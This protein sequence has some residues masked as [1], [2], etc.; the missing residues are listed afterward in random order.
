MRNVIIQHKHFFLFIVSLSL[1]RLVYINFIPLTPQEAY[2]WY[3][4]LKPALSYFDHPPMAAYSIWLGTW[5]FGKSV[6]GVK[7]M[8]VV[9]STLTNILIYVTVLRTQEEQE[10]SQRKRIA[11]FIIILFNLTIFAHLYS[12]VIVPDSPLLFFWILIIFLTREFLKSGQK[13]YLFLTAA[14]LGVGIVSKYTALAVLPAIF[15][16][17][18]LNPD[19]RRI[20]LKPYPYLALALA[21]IAFG[22]VIYWNFSHDWVSFKFQFGQRTTS[23]IKPLQLK[24]FYQ[25]IASQLFVLTPYI[26]ILILVAVK[27]FL[28]G[29]RKFPRERFFFL[30]SIFIIGGFVLYSFRS[31]VKLN[32]LLPGYIGLIILAGLLFYKENIF[33]SKWMKT[34]LVSSLV[35]VILSH[36]VLLIPNIPLKDG[37]TWSGW[38]DA[39]KRISEIQIAHGTQRDCFIFTNSY[40]TASLLR[41]YLPVEQEVYAQNI[42]DEPALQFDIWGVPDSLRGKKA[43]YVFSDRREYKDNLDKLEKYFSKI[44]FIEKF[45]YR[46]MGEIPTRTIY[47]YLGEN[48]AGKNF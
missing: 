24:Y 42:Y 27:K 31:L 48:Y 35:L 29:W 3:Y 36:L 26:V 40:K 25:L 28:F 7:V 2:Y 10:P 6:F 20:L 47:C 4:S 5:L 32:W 41:F 43:L 13:K 30:T 11:L 21:I 23:D 34:G 46:F 16:E 44:Q 37:N 1:F 33:S 38:E 8:A 18:L 45:E 14:A 9:W 39:A 19:R 17:L 22:P 12:V 15:L